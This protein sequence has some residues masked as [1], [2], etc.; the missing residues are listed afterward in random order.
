MKIS[1]ISLFFLKIYKKKEEREKGFKYYCKKCDFGTF[2]KDIINNHNNTIKHKYNILVSL[3]FFYLIIL[4][5]LH[6][7]PI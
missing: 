7:H 4:H 5:F 1:N 3:F 6:C 2:S